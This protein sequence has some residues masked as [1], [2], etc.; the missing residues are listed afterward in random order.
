MPAVYVVALAEFLNF[1]T[2][3]LFLHILNLEQSHLLTLSIYL[4]ATVLQIRENPKINAPGISKYPTERG[5]N[6]VHKSK[7]FLKS[8][9][10]PLRKVKLG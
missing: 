8:D 9:D 7:I 1:V 10:V 4:D 6:F 3:L 2:F 5:R